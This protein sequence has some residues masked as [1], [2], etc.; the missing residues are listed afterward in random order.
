MS[1]KL[2]QTARYVT[3]VNGYAVKGTLPLARALTGTFSSAGTVV[4]GTGTL[5]T[6]EIVEG[7]WLFST[8]TNELR[9]VEG[10]S[11]DTTLRLE[12][13]FSVDQ[14][15]QATKTCRALYFTIILTVSGGTSVT[16]NGATYKSEEIISYNASN[17]LMPW[18]YDATGSELTFDVSY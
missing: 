11:T 1:I 9:R 2:T 13:A 4:I 16:I 8:T 7:D 10:V 18:Y 3:G 15:T 17:C 12:Q 5:F 6:T 14:T